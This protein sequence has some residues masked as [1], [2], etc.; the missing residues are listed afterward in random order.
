M[1]LIESEQSFEHTWSALIG[2]VEVNPNITL[3]AVIDHGAAAGSV[4][5]ELAPNRVAVFGNPAL[6]SPLIRRNQAGDDA[7]PGGCGADGP[8]DRVSP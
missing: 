2:A 8:A 3:V 7:G 6:G 4:G 5:S 1:A